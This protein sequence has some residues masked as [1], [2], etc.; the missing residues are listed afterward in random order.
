MNDSWDDFAADWDANRDVIEYSEKAFHRLTEVANF[1]GGEV[2]DFGCGTGLL[3]EK[4]SPMAKTVV[5]LDTSQ[6]M[7][8]ILAAKKLPNVKPICGTLSELLTLENTLYQTRFKLVVASSVCA[9]VPDYEETLL[10]IKSLLKQDGMF[11]QW[12]WFSS[13]GSSGPGF[14]EK[15]MCDAIEKAGFRS[16]AVSTEF[17]MSTPE[18]DATVLMAVAQK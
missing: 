10:Q 4:L 12:D 14:T 1:E 11:V 15:Q 16:F 6:K 5:S 18:G 2:F 9:F 7:I 8:E 17:S 3:T 13:G